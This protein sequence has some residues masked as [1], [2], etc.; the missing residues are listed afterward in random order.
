MEVE[1][2]LRDA[3]LGIDPEIEVQTLVDVAHA[4]DFV[5]PGLRKGPVLLIMST[6]RSAKVSNDYATLAA[7]EWPGNTIPSP[8]VGSI[9]IT[10][11]SWRPIPREASR[12]P[13]TVRAC[14]RLA[15][16]DGP[17]VAGPTRSLG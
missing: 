11:Q 13:T 10:R 1:R 14:G 4:D 5:H 6:R 3:R 17:A 9:R 8:R 16:R 7:P 15:A 12:M 2:T